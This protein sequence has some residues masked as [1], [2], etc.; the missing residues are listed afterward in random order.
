MV[1]A[2][3]EKDPYVDDYNVS[4]LIPPPPPFLL[5]R[6]EIIVHHRFIM[7]QRD[8]RGVQLK[9]REY[10]APNY[11]LSAAV[12]NTHAWCLSYTSSARA[13]ATLLRSAAARGARKG[14]KPLAMYHPCRRGGREGRRE[15]GQGEGEGRGGGVCLFNTTPSSRVRLRPP[16]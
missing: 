9:P 6:R 11:W 16:L 4:T 10:N 14:I 12:N 1:V 8:V 3:E 5:L 2:D 13:L 15:G 7:C